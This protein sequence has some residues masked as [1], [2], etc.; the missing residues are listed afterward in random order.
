MNVKNIEF[1]KDDPKIVEKIVK[2]DFTV[3]GPKYGQ[4]VKEINKKVLSGE[5]EIKEDG[6]KVGDDL[7]F[8]EE[9]LVN[10]KSRSEKHVVEGDGLV[11]VALDIN[12]TEELRQEGIARDIV[13]II[14][15][16]RKKADFDVADRINISLDTGSEI[17]K[18]VFEKYDAYIRKE[19]LAEKIDLEKTNGEEVKIEKE[20]ATI[21]VE[22]I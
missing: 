6:V 20:T 21:K 4:R 19:T 22:K 11:L 7:L 17:L 8:A 9:V 2:L 1:K 12:I 10:F 13:R 18:K 16:L 15:D 3:A 14:Q 5:F